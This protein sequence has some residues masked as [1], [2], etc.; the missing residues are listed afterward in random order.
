M[1]EGTKA[2]LERAVGW[3][4]PRGDP[5]EPQRRADRRRRVRRATAVG[6]ALALSLGSVA[7]LAVAFLAESPRERPADDPV[8]E[9]YVRV[10]ER[11]EALESQ[12]A[13]LLNQA[14]R[15]HHR[16]QELQGMVRRLER[17]LAT[18]DFLPRDR[19]RLERRLEALAA[20]QARPRS[21][22][23]E[24]EARLSGLRAE[25]VVAREHLA[26]LRE[27]LR[28]RGSATAAVEGRRVTPRR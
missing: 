21:V 10:A 13:H 8:R 14:R 2:L 27:Q 23:V 22:L 7:F 19:L 25:L 28:A 16:I 17:V 9:Q 1:P 18:G 6:L 20:Q 24:A 3:Y 11:V 15:L 5:G 12:E 4:E 26:R